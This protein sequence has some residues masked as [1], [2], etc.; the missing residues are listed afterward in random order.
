MTS[1]NNNNAKKADSPAMIAWKQRHY[2]APPEVV[3]SEKVAKFIAIVKTVAKGSNVVG[4]IAWKQAF[5]TM[6]TLS[7]ELDTSQQ[8]EIAVAMTHD[9]ELNDA[10]NMVLGTAKLLK[11]Q[12]QPQKQTVETA[13]STHDTMTCIGCDRKIADTDKDFTRFPSILCGTCSKRKAD[14]DNNASAASR[15][16]DKCPGDRWCQMCED[17][18]CSKCAPGHL[19]E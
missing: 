17:K 10:M 7:T 3:H 11:E 4:D 14:S 5:K 9:Q 8:D 12:K 13:A 15:Y 1:S 2:V 16:C 18:F 19:C 6:P